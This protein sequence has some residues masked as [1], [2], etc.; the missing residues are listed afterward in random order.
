MF[1]NH[2]S[3]E[4]KQLVENDNLEETFEFLFSVLFEIKRIRCKKVLKDP[5]HFFF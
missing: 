2:S 1:L 4:N 5:H 3:L